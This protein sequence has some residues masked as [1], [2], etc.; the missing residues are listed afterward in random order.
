MAAADG[1]GSTEELPGLARLGILAIDGIHLAD[2]AEFRQHGVRVGNQETLGWGQSHL[3]RMMA[4]CCT[5]RHVGDFEQASPAH[6]CHVQT[7]MD[8]PRKSTCVSS[9]HCQE[10]AQRGSL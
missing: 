5:T 3:V 1:L 2:V 10:Y 8:G 4:G 7:A 6:S 9:L